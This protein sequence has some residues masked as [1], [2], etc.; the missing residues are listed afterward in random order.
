MRRLPFPPVT[1][2]FDGR[3]YEVGPDQVWGLI[4][5]IED[6][7][8]RPKLAIRIS[9]NDPPET[10]IAEAYCAAL[11]YAGARNIEP[12]DIMVGGDVTALL[13]K[14][15]ELF[16]IL[17]LAS[18]PASMADSGEAGKTKAPVTKMAARQKR[19]SKSG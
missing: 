2:T 13:H 4:G 11:R 9:Q 1:L 12:R 16:T 8:S 10:K 14:A 17:N 7:I 19:R 6:V 18:A 3:D 15:M 5:A